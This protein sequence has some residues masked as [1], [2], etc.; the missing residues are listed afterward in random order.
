MSG[1][2]RLAQLRPGPV[3]SAIFSPA[4]PG[5]MVAAC[6]ASRSCSSYFHCLRSYDPAIRVE[7]CGVTP[8]VSGWAGPTANDDGSWI[9]RPKTAATRCG[10]SR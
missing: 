1:F 4:G 9:L 6:T 7:N 8:A 10:P 3:V 2:Q 5:S